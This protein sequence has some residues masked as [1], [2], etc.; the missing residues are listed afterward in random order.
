MSN[1]IFSAP[2]DRAL[3]P[4]RSIGS[5][6]SM[7]PRTTGGAPVGGTPKF[8]GDP[9][10]G[11]PGALKPTQP[12]D[13]L[14]PGFSRGKVK[15][16]KMKPGITSKPQPYQGPIGGAKQDPQPYRGPIGGTTK[17]MP[18]YPQG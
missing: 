11:G 4:S 13:K 5:G 14:D 16:P 1:E 15:P 8:G 9:G 12:N 10:F 18:Y 17:T 3:D 6:P 7:G 2:R